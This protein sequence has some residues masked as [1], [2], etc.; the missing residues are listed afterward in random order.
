MG[1]RSSGCSQAGC[2][3]GDQ[4]WR[5]WSWWEVCKSLNSSK[6][7]ELEKMKPKNQ[8][9]TKPWV[10]PFPQEFQLSHMKSLIPSVPQLPIWDLGRWLGQEGLE[11][12]PKELVFYPRD[13]YS[14][15]N[16]KGELH[17]SPPQRFPTNSRIAQ[18]PW[19]NPRRFSLPHTNR[20]KTKAGRCEYCPE[21]LSH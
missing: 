17:L 21:T 15:G 4:L 6:I 19:I 5:P 18:G 9:C 13:G 1:N 8:G 3:A 16:Q 20:E 11:T 14:A 2:G 12:A 7:P 10:S